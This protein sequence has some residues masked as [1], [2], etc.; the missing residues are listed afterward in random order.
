MRNCRSHVQFIFFNPISAGVLENQDMLRGGQFDPPP[1]NPMFDDKWYIIGKLSC[2]TFRICNLWV[3]K[4]SQKI[5]TASDHYFLS[6]VKK[7]TGGVVKLTPPPAGIGLN[8]ITIS[9]QD[10]FEP[11][12]YIS[13]N[14]FIRRWYWCICRVRLFFF[15]FWFNVLA[16]P[17]YWSK[18]K[19]SGWT[20]K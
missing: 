10:W 11:E 15:N 5:S 8:K 9:I 4:K 6:Y 7:T 13:L 3:C 16:V 17:V 14:L 19:S 18:Y 1:L 2:S 20:S 12:K